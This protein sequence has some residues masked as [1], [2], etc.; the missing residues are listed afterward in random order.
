MPRSNSAS[1]RARF[2]IC[3]RARIAQ[4][5]LGLSGA[6][7]PTSLPLFQGTWVCGLLV[8]FMMDLLCVEP[9]GVDSPT[10]CAGP[11]RGGLTLA[12]SIFDLELSAI[13]LRLQ[14]ALIGQFRKLRGAP[15]S[16]LSTA[17]STLSVVRFP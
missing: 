14:P 11:R 2:S 9:G 4:T 12:R 3:R 6:F 15:L 13:G 7:C 1:S 17:Q 16:G 10:G 5:S 8:H